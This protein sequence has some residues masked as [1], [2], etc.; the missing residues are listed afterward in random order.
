[1]QDG[2]RGKLGVKTYRENIKSYDLKD[3]YNFLFI[4]FSLG[5]LQDEVLGHL[6]R[7][8]GAT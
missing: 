3:V 7:P 1:M 6:T 5:P 2:M 4:I 8:N